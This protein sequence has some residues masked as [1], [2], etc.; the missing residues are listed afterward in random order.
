MNSAFVAGGGPRDARGDGVEDVRRE[1]A[2]AE[3]DGRLF[4]ADDDR[5]LV[6]RLEHADLARA[7]GGSDPA[8]DRPALRRR[9]EHAAG[10]FVEVERRRG[11]GERRGRRRRRALPDRLDDS[12]PKSA[13]ALAAPSFARAGALVMSSNVSGFSSGTRRFERTRRELQDERRFAVVAERRD[14]VVKAVGADDD[15]S[16]PLFFSAKTSFRR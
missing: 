16:G 5:L 13:V 15:E 1:V 9:H 2:N 11:E 6:G 12:P 4:N 3:E 10:H 14:V 8:A 7:V